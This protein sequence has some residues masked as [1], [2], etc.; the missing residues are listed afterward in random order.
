[1]RQDIYTTHKITS[2]VIAL[3]FSIPVEKTDVLTPQ[4]NP[5]QNNLLPLKASN[6]ISMH[7][8]HPQNLAEA[9]IRTSK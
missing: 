4:P 8:P 2:N 7:L 1:M 6:P 9:Q 5:T 3:D